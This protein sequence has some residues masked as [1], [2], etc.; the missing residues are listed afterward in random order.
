MKEITNNEITQERTK[1][2]ESNKSKLNKERN[3]NEL[4]K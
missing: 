4:T 3:Q 2:N 1:T